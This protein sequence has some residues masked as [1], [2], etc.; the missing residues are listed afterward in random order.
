M[1]NDDSAFAYLFELIQKGYQINICDRTFKDDKN[2]CVAIR[3]E[4]GPLYLHRY[5]DLFDFDMLN[6]ISVDKVLLEILKDM[7]KQLDEGNINAILEG[8]VG[9]RTVT[10]KL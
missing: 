3:M 10:I 8:S 9:G 5:I 4:K 2:K 6:D 7:K 1:S